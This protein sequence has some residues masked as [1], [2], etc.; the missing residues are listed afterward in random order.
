MRFPSNSM[1]LILKS[2]PM[3]VMKE[4]V[5]ASSQNRSKRHD[6]PTPAVGL[7]KLESHGTQSDDNLPESPMRSN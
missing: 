2:I 7:V 5:H 4:G 6:F 1:V 3:V